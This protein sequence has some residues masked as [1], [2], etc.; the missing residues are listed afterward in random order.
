MGTLKQDF[1]D[2]KKAKAEAEYCVTAMD[3]YRQSIEVKLPYEEW[4]RNL[5]KINTFCKM[6]EPY[7]EYAKDPKTHAKFVE[8]YEALARQLRSSSCFMECEV[9]VDILGLGQI[10]IDVEDST[11]KCVNNRDNGDICEHL[12]DGCGKFRELVK[13]QMLAANV[14]AAQEKQNVAKMMLMNHFRIFNKIK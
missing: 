4:R 8:R 12:C 10:G 5:A 2:W 6:M 14:R 7:K 13:Y 3:S 11:L 1:A 9:N